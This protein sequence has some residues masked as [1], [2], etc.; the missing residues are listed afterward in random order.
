MSASSH[1]L[2]AASVPKDHA[3]ASLQAIALGDCCT[4]PITVQLPTDC[5]HSNLFR[6]VRG[7]IGCSTH[8]D[9]LILPGSDEQ[10]FDVPASLVSLE[11]TC[12]CSLS[13]IDNYTVVVMAVDASIEPNYRDTFL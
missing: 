5:L 1:P 7:N 4:L 3:H 13:V 9:I 6:I 8:S 2:A 12:F 11:F 10:P